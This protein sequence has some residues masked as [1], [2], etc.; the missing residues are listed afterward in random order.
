MEMRRA[1]NKLQSS[2]WAKSSQVY[3]RQKPVA[4][5]SVSNALHFLVAICRRCRQYVS[6]LWDETELE[7]QLTSAAARETA[8]QTATED[9]GGEF[10]PNESSDEVS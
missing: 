8:F 6:Q 9:D 1:N 5:A 4:F 2:S 10:K 7:V 3:G